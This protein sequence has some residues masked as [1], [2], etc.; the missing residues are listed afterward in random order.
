MRPLRSGPLENF[1]L[2]LYYLWVELPTFL[3]YT[4]FSF[5]VVAWIGF[6]RQT[7]SANVRSTKWSYIAL[8]ISNLLMYLLLVAVLIAFEAVP[9]VETEPCTSSSSSTALSDQQQA[10]YVVYKAI[11]A[12]FS[13]V[14]SVGILTFGL[15][16][17]SYLHVKGIA[18]TVRKQKFKVLAVTFISSLCFI[19]LA[20]V[21]LAQAKVP[22]IG[23]NPEFVWTFVG[24]ECF[25]CFC[26]AWVIGPRFKNGLRGTTSAGSGGGSSLPHAS[27]A[28]GRSANSSS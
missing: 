25:P 8:F 19:A 16:M 23:D 14:L 6:V 28:S 4:A 21:L 26:L 15:W 3:F 13:V 17:F 7:K 9:G 22:E 20:G 11:L 5:L 12:S 2:V 1:P 18:R 27:H 10:V 24:L